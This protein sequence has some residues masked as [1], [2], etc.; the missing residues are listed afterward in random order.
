MNKLI[1]IVKKNPIVCIAWALAIVTCFMVPPDKEYFAYF[2]YKTLVCLFC[3]LSVVCALKNIYFFRIV[4]QKII[5]VFKNT[6]S[7]IIALVYITFIG[8]M[9]IAN[10]M[11]LITFLPLGYFVLSDTNHKELMSFTFIMQNI[12]ANLGGMLTPFGNPQNLYLYSYFN[13]PTA[14]FFK[15]MFIPFIVS[16]TLITICC[17]FV[18]REELA[19]TSGEGD[20]QLNRRKSIIYIILFV[21]SVAIVFNVVNFIVGAVIIT[22]AI[23]Y[24]DREA[25]SDVDYGLLLTFCAF[26]IFSGNLARVDAIKNLLTGAVENNTLL[27]SVL[28]CQIISNVPSAIL[29]AK[30]TANY[31]ALLIGVNIGGAG[32]LIASLAS[33]ITLGQYSKYNPGK[34]K[35]YIMQFSIY[36]FSMLAILFAVSML[37]L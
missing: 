6:R 31:P 27:F 36:N 23:I 5:C 33:L 4:A 3:A 2:D 30:F 17:L 16:V 29:L 21:L 37:V 7:A 14:E 25:F 8:S 28:S 13:I 22:A 26:F 24:F 1:N 9:L 32:T 34:A 18:K 19:L 10:D 11:A 20:L 15:I 35:N 12:A